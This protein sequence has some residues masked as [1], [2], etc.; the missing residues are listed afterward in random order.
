MVP[1]PLAEIRAALAQAARYA[2]GSRSLGSPSPALVILPDAAPNSSVAGVM[3]CIR[4]HESGNYQE[5][6]HP[7]SGSGAYQYTPGTWSIWSSKAGYDG[8]LY[9]YQAPP[10]VQDA[11]TVF[12]LTHG[13]AHNW[14]PRY[15]NDPCTVAMP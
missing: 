6:S 9:A 12:T 4:Q 8:F 5:S 11:V 1:V 10:S 2:S 13:G 14:D 3:A 7:G 15:G